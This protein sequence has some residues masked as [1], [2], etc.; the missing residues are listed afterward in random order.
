MA[1]RRPKFLNDTDP[2]MLAEDI[3]ELD[4]QFSEI[5]LTSFV[6][7]LE[8][9]C[10]R[11]YKKILCVYHGR[12]L[13]F[14]YGEKDS[15]A[16]GQHLLNLLIQSPRFGVT[17]NAHI[18]EYSDKLKRAAG[19]ISPQALQLL[20]NERLARIY[21]DLDR[22]HTT[23]YTWGWLPNAVDMFH[24][25]FT[26]YL[27]SLL[28]EK[29]P[30][31]EVS[32]A[33]VTMS[34]SAEKSILNQEHE[35]LLRLAALKQA[36]HPAAGLE[37]AVQKHL[38]RF[39]HLK[40]L[41]FGLQGVYTRADI[42]K[43][44]RKL[45]K[46]GE[47]AANIVKKEEVV[48]RQAMQEKTKLAKLL[49]L[50]KKEQTLFDVYAEFAVTKAYR[51]DAQIYWAYKMD[52]IF[53]ELSRRLKLPLIQTRYLRPEEVMHSLRERVSNTLRSD[54]KK[55]ATFCIYYAEKGFDQFF[56]GA[57]AR[58]WKKK[59]SRQYSAQIKELS[60]QTACLGK[61]K[62]NVRI[63]NVIA[64]LKKM[65]TGDVLVS[66]ATNPDIV[67]AMKKAA[68]IVTEQGGVTS[69][70]AIVS[71]ELNIPCVI[72]T[73]IATKVLKDGDKVEVDA[74]KGLVKKL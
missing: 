63:I 57:K 49:A 4:F 29:L 8:K 45:T 21:V 18:R 5:W 26:G 65:K 69:H 40:H 17:V 39:F 48:R 60:G 59:V 11:N 33:L 32:A 66:I 67:P 1:R 46:S 2:W 50:S 12:D 7:D 52:F 30:L 6:N 36:K 62:G 73:K 51:R 3:P 41:W 15:F 42:T 19:T 20:S 55:R 31:D 43:E 44:I 23:L 34:V 47:L 27:K 22:L 72:G 58:A 16:F 37:K 24:N 56:Y 64:D 35:S 10:G 13:K 71:R 53:A 61:A 54:S 25:N 74:N 14:Y 70:A 38:Q 28:G 9:T 68:A